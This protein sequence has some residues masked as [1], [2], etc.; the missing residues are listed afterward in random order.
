MM[1]EYEDYERQVKKIRQQNEAVL[2]GFKAWLSDKGLSAKTINQHYGNIDFYINEFLVYEMPKTPAD[3]VDE[4]SFFF[5]G[6]F[7]CKA[8]WASA[9]S[10]KSNV[11]SLK[12]FYDFL[13]KREEV[14]AE[15]VKELKE[16]IKEEL[17]EWLEILE[18][19]D[20]PSVDFDNVW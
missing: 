10:I 17:P 15:D 18:R 6:W 2:E 3:R 13:Q 12:K 1:G 4:V 19:Y 14:S 16:T 9:S 5:G 7:V 20:D 11:A 8:M